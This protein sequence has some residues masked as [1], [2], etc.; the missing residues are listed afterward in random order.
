MLQVPEHTW[1]EDIKIYLDDYVNWTNAQFQQQ[2]ADR[3]Y[4]QPSGRGKSACQKL[5]H[6]D[7]PPCCTLLSDANGLAA[8]LHYLAAPD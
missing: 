2:L 6:R 5:V 4:P 8:H 3:C 7:F 1:G